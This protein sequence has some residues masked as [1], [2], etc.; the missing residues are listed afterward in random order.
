[1]WSALLG[2]GFRGGLFGLSGP[3]NSKRFIEASTL[4]RALRGLVTYISTL[5][6]RASARRRVSALYKT[7]T[8]LVGNLASAYSK[9]LIS[10]YG[11]CASSWNLVRAAYS[12]NSYYEKCRSSKEKPALFLSSQSAT[13]R[14]RFYWTMILVVETWFPALIR[15]MYIP[16]V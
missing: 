2:R 15:T 11:V 1:M 4:L 8:V 10:F 9:S 12:E 3:T 16:G 14:R 13:Y 6:R 7:F 5:P